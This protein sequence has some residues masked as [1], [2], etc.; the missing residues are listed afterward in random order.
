MAHLNPQQ[1]Y[2]GLKT[3][4]KGLAMFLVTDATLMFNAW[5]ATLPEDWN[6][7]LDAWPLH[8]TALGVAALKMAQNYYKHKDKGKP[9]RPSR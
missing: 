3:I 6:L 1:T 4:S 7:F 5:L 8:A 2:S 9:R